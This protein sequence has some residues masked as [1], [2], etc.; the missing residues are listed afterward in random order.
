[1]AVAEQQLK[2]RQEQELAGLDALETVVEP[3]QSFPSRLWAMLW[4]KLLAIVIVAGGN[5]S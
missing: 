3:T 2:Q 5:S 4:P 1:M